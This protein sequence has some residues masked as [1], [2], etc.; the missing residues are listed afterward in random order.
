MKLG[1]KIIK[2]RKEKKL[3]QEELA[4]KI[5]VSRQTISN[6]ELNITKPDVSQIKKFSKIFNISVDELLDNDIRDIIE[7]KISNTEKTTNK[8]SKNIK[9]LLI[10]IYF[11]ILA[12][13]IWVIVYYSTK[14]DFTNMYQNVW[15][16]SLEFDESGDTITDT[17][18][19]HWSGIEDGTFSAIV[20]YSSTSP[21]AYDNDCKICFPVY[22]DDC[23]TCFYGDTVLDYYNFG[24][25]F[26]DMI[27]FLEHR[28]N[29]LIYRGAICR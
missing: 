7:E 22:S 26:S 25:N 13:L 2:L 24:S 11:I 8:N 4:D 9:I 20:E 27:T 15:V 18:Y 14:K 10:T 5:G 28:K 16:C 21:T 23:K 1:N 19:L 17:Y 29:N 3:S 12:F 6:W